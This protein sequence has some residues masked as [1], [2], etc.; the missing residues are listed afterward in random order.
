MAD[1]RQSTNTC[2]P[3]F[4]DCQAARSALGFKSL[5]R[6]V[7]ILPGPTN[8]GANRAL[9]DPPMCVTE[10]CAYKARTAKDDA[11]C[12]VVRSPAGSCSSHERIFN[13]LCRRHMVRT[14]VCGEP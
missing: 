13:P 1:C 6:Q 3:A 4:G 9:S 7:R 2:T 5:L 10:P 14:T 12:G 11:S 8:T